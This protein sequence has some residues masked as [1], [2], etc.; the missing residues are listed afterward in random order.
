[1]QNELDDF[2]QLRRLL[3]L[4]RHEQP[5]PGYFHRFPGQVIARIRAGEG[6]QDSGVLGHWFGNTSWLGHF[7]G[8][9]ESQ[10]VLAAAVGVASCALLLAGVVVATESGE[11]G[12]TP[13]AAQSTMEASLGFGDRSS[14]STDIQPAMLAAFELTNSFGGAS[15][16]GALFPAQPANFIRMLGN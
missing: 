7:W 3:A 8:R 11:T 2:D 13:F 4:K 1:M 6:V 5:P 12:A 14:H 16:R 9:L 15:T 10:P